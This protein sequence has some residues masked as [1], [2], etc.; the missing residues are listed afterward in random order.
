MISFFF[1]FSG[2]N[3]TFNYSNIASTDRFLIK[4]PSQSMNFS[5]HQH[6][7][8]Y[9]YCFY[10]IFNSISAEKVIAIRLLRFSV[11]RFIARTRKCEGSWLEISD[12]TGSK[13][14]RSTAAQ[15]PGKFCGTL[16]NFWSSYYSSQSAIQINYYSVSDDSGESDLFE[17]E[18]SLFDKQALDPNSFSKQRYFANENDLINKNEKTKMPIKLHYGV[19]LG[20]Q[21]HQP[22][23]YLYSDCS[24]DANDA[25]IINSSGYPGIY[26]RNLKC[27]YVIEN[28]DSAISG[29]ANVGVKKN[30][31][32]EA[33]ES[34]FD[35]T[36]VL[37]NDD[38]QVDGSLCH[39]EPNLKSSS[40]LA[41]S[42]F[43]DT[44]PRSLECKDFLNVYEEDFYS[45]ST[46]FKRKTF[47]MRNICGLGRL[48]KIVTKSPNLTL[49]LISSSDGLFANSGFLF[50][51]ISQKKYFENYRFYNHF[52]QAH[53]KTHEEFS[54]IKVI[55][56]LQMQNCTSSLSECVVNISEDTLSEIYTEVDS[57]QEKSRQT[58]H[59]QI[60]KNSFKIGY[61]YGINQYH[62]EMFTLK[63]VLKTKRFNTIAIHLDRYEPS[64]TKKG[65]NSAPSWS[66]HAKISINKCSVNYLSL[67]TNDY[68]LMDE[69]YHVTK[70]KQIN[71]T[72]NEKISMKI[73]DANDLN[74]STWASRFFLV[75]TAATN[76]PISSQMRT[77]L[78]I[79]YFTTQPKVTHPAYLYDF[80]M[81]FEMIDFDWHTFKT[82]SVCDFVYNLRENS[83]T[84]QTSG[85]IEN[86]QS[87][88]FYKSQSAFLKCKYKF[89]GKH[90]Q[91]IK[92]SIESID[93]DNDDDQSQSSSHQQEDNETSK[94]LKC[95]NVYFN[96]LNR[97]SINNGK[98]AQMDRKLVFR[99][100]VQPIANYD[101]SSSA[102]NSMFDDEQLAVGASE[103]KMC[104]CKQNKFHNYVYLSKYDVVEV[105]YTVKLN[106]SVDLRHLHAQFRIK[107][108]FVD[109][110][111]EKYSFQNVKPAHKGRFI[112]MPNLGAYGIQRELYEFKDQRKFD[113]V[114][115]NETNEAI[116]ENI[117][118]NEENF[119]RMDYEAFR[120]LLSNNLNFY[121]KFMLIAPL[122][123]FIHI[124]FSELYIPQK[125]HE[126]SI[127]FYSNYTEHTMKS[128]SWTHHD[129][130]D[131]QAQPLLRLCA[132][133]SSD[134][135]KQAYAAGIK[136]PHDAIHSG[137][138]VIAEFYDE[139]IINSSYSC[140]NSMSKICF[141]TNEL[142]SE[143]NPFVQMNRV[144]RQWNQSKKLVHQGNFFNNLILE[145]L[146]NDL[147][148]LHFEIK[149]HFFAIDYATSNKAS[150]WQHKK[151]ECTFKCYDAN[152]NASKR[153][154][155][156]ESLVCDGEIQCIYNDLDER[157][158]P[159]KLN[160]RIIFVVL[161]SVILITLLVLFIFVIFRK[162]LFKKPQIP[163]H[164]IIMNSNENQRLN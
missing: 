110:K 75:K 129:K 114:N 103:N 49:E 32:A 99:E 55:E 135:S 157:N 78:I 4:N 67:E 26:L 106:K 51:F 145:I 96:D 160:P 41:S 86:P 12:I 46:S 89:I 144:E 72:M 74:N 137:S 127:K 7:S 95:E 59:S 64:S 3:R 155:L 158:C 152:Q 133:S 111:C 20:N 66:D 5:R 60:S 156:D 150:S 154:C 136:F 71:Q 31:L 9:L 28:I 44:G 69:N 109:R 73:C 101:E 91:Y 30:G 22:C 29:S 35:N 108:E 56:R 45:K 80:K 120:K 63:Y 126:N 79:K 146:S 151:N 130:L 149:Y 93:F 163:S 53:V 85:Y 100:L 104:L 161:C 116:P 43:C 19:M 1:L 58:R 132:L 123:H 36:G 21:Q 77:S 81:S 48:S 2:C 14:H 42:Y 33:S 8:R 24:K 153:V 124:E 117:Y 147:N 82:D 38:F 88:I 13:S 11:G 68:L 76:S 37:I 142:E 113:E 162:F 83:D 62:E 39:F 102:H 84:L 138:M 121:C 27:K 148:N 16:H 87:S 119:E 143:L 118:A 140:F 128:R 40:H 23:S 65:L 25:C 122:N 15:Q 70:L 97:R 125:C 141:M 98:C 159:Y 112:Y 52:D 139:S 105:E 10:R 131:H 17:F 90:N 115:R 57:M 54:S 107:Y 34:E 61:L 134:Y 47:L 164:I 50:Y 6:K 94:K 92:L 18:I